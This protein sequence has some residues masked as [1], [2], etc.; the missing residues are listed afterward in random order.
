VDNQDLHPH[1]EG[2]RVVG[3]VSSNLHL[4]GE[5]NDSTET[6]DDTAKKELSRR[7]KTCDVLDGC[8]Q[9]KM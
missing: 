4:F 7:H 8:R 2:A 6:P 3:I 5:R 1:K 9:R